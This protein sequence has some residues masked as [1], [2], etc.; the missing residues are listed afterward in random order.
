MVV[1]NQKN[2]HLS[3][4]PWINQ[5]TYLLEKSGNPV[6]HSDYNRSDAVAEK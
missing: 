3:V 6:D 5:P 4:H 1:L 2:Y